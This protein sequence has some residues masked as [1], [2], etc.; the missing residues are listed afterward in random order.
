VSRYQK[1]KT[2]LDLLEQETVSGSGISWA[3]CK[4]APCPMQ[5]TM[6]SPHHSDFTGQ[7]PSCHPTNSIRAMNPSMK[8]SIYLNDEFHNFT[9]KSRAQKVLP[10]PMNEN[11]PLQSLSLPALSVTVR[12]VTGVARLS[13]LR[14]RISDRLPMIVSG[15]IRRLASGIVR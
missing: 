6:A 10:S 14:H 4:S 13:I 12:P 11:K 5:I 7:M 9:A 3:T 2:N 8:N 1:G 15:M